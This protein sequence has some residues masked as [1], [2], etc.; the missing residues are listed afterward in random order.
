[1]IPLVLA[2]LL[3][4]TVGDVLA[5]VVLETRTGQ[6]VGWTPGRTTVF[7]F[8]AFWCDTWKV[9]LPRVDVARRRLAGL[10]IDFRIVAVDGRWSD[11]GPPN[12]WLDRGGRWSRSIGIAQVPTTVVVDPTGRVVF[13]RSGTL[14][15]ADLVA[16]CTERAIAG[17]VYLTFDDFPSASGSPELLDAVRQLGVRATFFCIGRNAEAH[18]DLVRRAAAEGHTLAVHN[19][20]HA[21]ADPQIARCEALLTQLAGKAQRLYRGPGSEAILDQG[22]PVNLPIVDPYDFLR[23]GP[24]ELVRRVLSSVKAKS[25]IQLHAGV[26]DTLT[27][28][29]QIVYRLCARGF[30]FEPLSAS[31]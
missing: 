2:V 6:T 27:A 13:A 8:C 15:S 9:Q 7:T 3:P 31:H 21:A 24:D 10:P 1:M 25:V 16:A 23:P 4:P 22:R 19:W 17:P 20:D 18:P 11:L 12:A 29:P 26:P 5:P 30:R 28:L 14:R